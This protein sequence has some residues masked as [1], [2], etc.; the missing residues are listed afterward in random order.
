MYIPIKPNEE[1]QQDEQGQG[2]EACP[3][4]KMDPFG[5]SGNR[6]SSQIRTDLTD[7]AHGP[8]GSI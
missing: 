2:N 5:V 4:L 1:E 3:N 6:R 8:D 7:P